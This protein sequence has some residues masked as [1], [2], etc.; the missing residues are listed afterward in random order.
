MSDFLDDNYSLLLDEQERVEIEA[1]DDSKNKFLASIDLS[2]FP[3]KEDWIAWMKANWDKELVNIPTDSLRVNGHVVR[4]SFESYLEDTK[5]I[6]NDDGTYS[7]YLQS[8]HLKAAAKTPRH[9]FFKTHEIVRPPEETGKHFDLGEALHACIL[10]PTRFSRFVV[11]PKVNSATHE[12]VDQL[13]VFWESQ[14]ERVFIL[15]DQDTQLAIERAKANRQLIA[16]NYNLLNRSEIEERI[17]AVCN[18]LENK[19]RTLR[20]DYPIENDSENL[21]IIYQEMTDLGWDAPWLAKIISAM[22]MKKNIALTQAKV[23]R[24]EKQPFDVEPL[25]E[26]FQTFC[27]AASASRQEIKNSGE[28]LFRNIIE[29]REYIEAIKTSIGLEEVNERDMDIIRAIKHAYET[30][31]GGIIPRIIKRTKRENSIYAD[32]FNGLPLKARPDAMAFEE[33]IGVNAIISVK[34][35]SAQDIKKFFYDTAKYGYEL[36]EGMYQEVASYV[37]G[38]QFKTTLTIMF[39]TVEPYGVALFWWKPDDLTLGVQKFRMACETAKQAIE[40][41]KYP[42]YEMYAEEGHFGVIDMVLPYWSYRML[43][44]GDIDN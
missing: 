6:I 9:L 2:D 41:G 32:D 14:M 10:E 40:E 21:E 26:L 5:F 42:G 15:E 37:T 39:Q 4:D 8:S 28:I 33:N 13:I 24:K 25:K 18:Y 29:K 31:G 16:S 43:E 3:K 35:T 1:S 17:Q 23:L 12:G 7:G 38:R 34:S 30:Y 44:P 20:E 22:R 27:D 36:T 19:K 11:T